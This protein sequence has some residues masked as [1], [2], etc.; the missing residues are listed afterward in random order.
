MIRSDRILDILGGVSGLVLA[1]TGEGGWHKG[2]KTVK[3]VQNLLKWIG[4]HLLE[5]RSVE[6]DLGFRVW[7]SKEASRPLTGLGHGAAG[8]AVA[9]FR[10][11]EILEDKR[12]LEAGQEAIAYENSVYD[13]EAG[14]WPDFRIDPTQKKRPEKQFMG[15]YCAGAPG[16]GLAR[17]DGLKRIGD[18]AGS[19]E[20]TGTLTEDIHRADRFVRSIQNEGRNHLCCG[21][22]GRIDFLIEE[23]YRL[24]DDDARDFAHRKLSALITGK[25][26]RGHYN[27]HTVNGKYYYNP[28]LFQGT[29]GVGYEILR[30]LAPDKIKSVLI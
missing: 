28:T 2:A 14:N 5:R 25:Q 3:H 27:F 12:F 15:G 7:K 6:T 10:L 11:Y 29:A 13:E 30:F 24:E 22:A 26:K 17:L 18:A 16:I 4:E 9:L 8:I 19:E 21:S 23:G 20:L 1:L